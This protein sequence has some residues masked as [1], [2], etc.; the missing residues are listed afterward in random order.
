MTK[1]TVLIEN[2]RL[3]NRND[4][5]PENG[6]ALYIEANGMRVLFDTAMTETFARNAERL[7]I[8][9]QVVDM[10]IISHYHFDHGG[11]LTYFLETNQ[12]AKV[13]L[14]RWNVGDC[15]F[16]AFGIINK[17]VGLDRA[18]FQEHADRFVFV[19][20]FT[21]VASHV[22]ILTEVESPYPQ[23]RGNRHLFVKEGN[24]RQLD[25]FKHELEM[26]FQEPEGLVVFTGCSHQGILNMVA[27][28]SEQFDGLP[29]KAVFGGFHLIGL[30][31]L[32]QMAESKSE[33]AGMGR[34]M[35]KYPIEKAYTGHCTG[36]R[37][38]R[39]LKEIM[40]EKLAYLSTGSHV[41]V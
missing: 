25:G 36:T 26:V 29:I 11:G 37:A 6:L 38:Y 15:Y 20:T 24:A 34:E 31:L 1:V 21:E 3:A 5:R 23:P 10:A 8:D 7:G 17:F 28:V 14:R 32:N 30:P 22:F 33:V 18:V 19:D 13:Y 27:T 12:K 16:R 2:T 40:G 4:L 41:E 39:I 35:L 9:I